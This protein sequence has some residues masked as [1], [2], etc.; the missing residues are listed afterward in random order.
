MFGELIE[1]KRIERY[2]LA[3]AHLANKVRLTWHNPRRVYQ[4]RKVVAPNYG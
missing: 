3:L 4:A 2:E 1:S